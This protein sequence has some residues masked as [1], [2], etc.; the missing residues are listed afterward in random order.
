MAALVAFV[1]LGCGPGATV[2]TSRAAQ[3]ES[4]DFATP[5][6][7]RALR[8]DGGEAF[9]LLGSVHLGRT[10]MLPLPASVDRAY[11]RSD[12]LVLEVD[13]DELESESAMRLARRYGFVKAPETLSDRVSEDTLDA[14]EDYLEDRGDALATYLQFEPWFLATHLTKRE[15][16]R[17]GLDPEFG[18]D[19]LF[20]TRAARKK[21]IAALETAES[22]FA[23]LAGLPRDVQERMLLD[24][25]RRSDE[26][27]SETESLIRAWERGDDAELAQI[28]FRSLH[29][30]PELD[31]FYEQIVFGRNE[32]MAKRLAVLAQDGKLRFVVVGAAHLIGKRGIPA[33]LRDYGFRLQKTRE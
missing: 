9:Y 8:P 33:L 25:L 4:P 23:L 10:S 32:S 17:L 3:A 27:A 13:F 12:E 7:W 21:P 2:T 19:Q 15:A 22:Q 30:T 18:I 6:L 31:I 1:G 26:L 24:A 29:R 28:A 11:A 5:T 20:A 16:L 14:L